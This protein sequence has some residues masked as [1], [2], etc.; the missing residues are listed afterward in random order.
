MITNPRKQRCANVRSEASNRMRVLVSKLPQANIRRRRCGFTLIELLV[1]IAIIAILA[2]MLLPALSQAREQAK[3]A[4]CKNNLKQVH[5]LMTGYA[6]DYDGSLS[7]NGLWSE[8]NQLA[9]TQD[10]TSPWGDRYIRKN[11]YLPEGKWKSIG[12]IFYCPSSP[13]SPIFM[14][15]QSTVECGRVTYLFLNNYPFSTANTGCLGGK[16]FRFAPNSTLAQDWIIK[17]TAST[18]NPAVYRS[19]HKTGGNVLTSAGSVTFSPNGNFKLLNNVTGQLNMSAS[20]AIK[21]LASDR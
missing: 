2:S 8:H 15:L 1:V 10:G 17:P 11:A 14:E 3:T 6:N 13:A 16:L 9:C 7:G 12:Q 21:P 19:S 4:L 18:T 20:Y 5:L